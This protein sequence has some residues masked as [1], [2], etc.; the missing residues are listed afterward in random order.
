MHPRAAVFLI[1]FLFLSPFSRVLT[2][3]SLIGV[4]R[5]SKIGMGGVKN[6]GLHSEAR[7]APIHACSRVNMQRD[8]VLCEPCIYLML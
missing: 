1:V 3:S 2:F 5:R 8:D 6:Q 4:L 7:A